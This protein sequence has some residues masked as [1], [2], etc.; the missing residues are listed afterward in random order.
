MLGD[1]LTKRP[2]V[3]HLVQGGR[4]QVAMGTLLLYL[5]DLDELQKLPR[6]RFG[7]NQ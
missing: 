2:V 3:T 6:W 4:L 7:I 5:S 1:G